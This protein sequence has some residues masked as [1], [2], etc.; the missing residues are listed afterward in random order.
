[1]TR[2]VIGPFEIHEQLGKGGIGEVYA[3]VDQLLG[4]PVA[5][6]ALRPE[7]SRDHGFVERFRSEATNLARLNHPNITTLY[8]LHKEG[9]ELYM[10][11]ELVRGSTLESILSRAGRL[12][13]NEC[14][15]IMAQAVAGLT[16]AHR[17]GVIH[18]DI[19]PANLMVTDSG[20]LKIMDFGIARIQG[21]QRM[22]RQ[23]DLIGTLAYMSPEQLKGAEGD[24]RSD[25]YSLAMVLYE[26]LSGDT[27]FHATSEYDLIRAQVEQRPPPLAGQVPGL[28]PKAE[29]VMMQALAKNPDERF[30]TVDAFGRALGTTAIQ[31]DAADI[32]KEAVVAR[33]GAAPPAATRLISTGAAIAS[34]AAPLAAPSAAPAGPAPAAQPAPSGGGVL[35][36]LLS[37]LGVPPAMHKPVMVLGGVAAVLV[38]G[39]GYVVIGPSTPAPPKDVTVASRELPSQSQPQKSAVPPASATPAAPA[40]IV[41]PSQPSSPP[42]VSSP[43]STPTPVATPAPPPAAPAPPAAAPT[44]PPAVVVLPDAPSAKSSEVVIIT[45]KQDETVP[46][47]PSTPTAAPPSAAPSAPSAAQPTAPPSAA[48]GA[49]SAAQPAATPP[50]AAPSAPSAAQPTAPPSKAAAAPP[51]KAPQVASLPPSTKAPAARSSKSAAE[52]PALEGPVTE[53]LDSGAIVV[54]GQ[55]INLYGIRGESGRP[56]SELQNYIAHMGNRV[57]CFVRPANSFECHVQGYDVAEAAVLNGAARASEG[58][59]SKYRTAEQEARAAHRGI[60][61]M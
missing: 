52:T 51:A 4:R 60:W 27:P 45:P 16:Y 21:S 23:G 19:K 48:P 10:V 18:R 20:L 33:W 40:A 59:P 24:A 3:G 58:A 54:A 42:A 39:L 15:A 56:A 26:L 17:M 7:F 47:S 35:G 37:R 41:S 34:G 14:I 38:V 43:P 2:R 30:P 49:P 50:S 5:I 36:T 46:A 25:L 6:K 1:M 9:D 57:T 13:L 8:S 22:T 12:G 61:G 31:G 32:V 44:A 29:A 53:V 11:M 28:D 55:V